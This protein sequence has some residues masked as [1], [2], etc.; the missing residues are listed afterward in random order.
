[1]STPRALLPGR[2]Y[3]IAETL[4]HGGRMRLLDRIDGY[5]SDWLRACVRI[6]A[7]SLLIEPQGMPAWVGIEYMAQAAAAWG[8]IEQLQRGERPDIGLLLGSRRFD[9]TAGWFPLD[10]ELQITARL[11][12]GDDSDLAVFD[13]DVQHNGQRLAWADIKAY[14]PQDVEKYLGM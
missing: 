7:D 4:P 8:G 2:H 5:G 14:R 10:A 3:E 13:C 1:M 11:V 6:R 9:A 12:L